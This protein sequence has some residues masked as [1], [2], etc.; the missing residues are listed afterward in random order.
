MKK[1]FDKNNPPVIE[2]TSALPTVQEHELDNN[3]LH[4]IEMLDESDVQDVR[5]ELLASILDIAKEI[6][7]KDWPRASEVVQRNVTKLD[8]ALPDDLIMDMIDIAIQDPQIEKMTKAMGIMGGY[9]FEELA[10]VPEIKDLVPDVGALALI[11]LA[12]GYAEE[13]AKILNEVQILRSAIDP[14]YPLPDE[15]KLDL[16]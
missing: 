16:H 6:A 7:Q 13:D 1:T 4:A 11:E 5:I 15:A 14:S 8:C 12:H 10:D 2:P 9:R 3:L